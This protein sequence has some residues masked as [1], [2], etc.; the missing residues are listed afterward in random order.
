MSLPVSVSRV[1]PVPLRLTPHA[2]Q[3][4]L[5]R[6]KLTPDQAT[7]LLNAHRPIFTGFQCADNRVHVIFYSVPDTCCFFAVAN[8][9]DGAVAT[10]LTHA[11][12]RA[13]YGYV[14]ENR[15][16]SAKR[17]E[18]PQEV[19][20]TSIVLGVRLIGPAG[21]VVAR[22]LGRAHGF[23]A[24]TAPDRL[25]QDE[26]LRALICER[27]AERGIDFDALIGVTVRPTQDGT[28]IELQLDGMSGTGLLLRWGQDAIQHVS[29]DEV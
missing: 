21:R 24:A 13:R 5:E 9:R 18:V 22:N 4:V 26:D 20:T 28:P 23:S 7:K 8:M 10:V 15:L 19:P 27:C 6:T 1:A 12:Y 14:S 17:R 16:A 25:A 2:Q 29:A 11:Q 3:R